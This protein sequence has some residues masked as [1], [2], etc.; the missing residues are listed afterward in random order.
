MRYRLG[1]FTIIVLSFSIGW[2][3]LAYESAIDTT[4][5]VSDPLYFEIRPGQS[6]GRVIDN[7]HSQGLLKN[8]HYFKLMGRLKNAT[9]RLKAG[10]Y[11]IEPGTTW[12]QLLTMMVNG[13]VHQYSITLI[14]GWTF[15][16]IQETIGKSP[17]LLQTLQE[18]SD[19]QIM[20]SISGT[21]EHPEGRFFPDTYFFTKNTTDIAL[22]KRSYMRMRKAL[23]E[24][25]QRREEGLPL[26]TPYQALILASVVE[27]ETAK[28]EE[29]RIIAGVF[30][31]RLQR[32]MK[33]QTD[34]TVIYG[35]GSG[36]QGNIR[37]R[38][39]RAD[40]PY[41]TYVHH[42]LPPTPIAMP[43]RDALHAVLHPQNGSS[44]YF[45]SRG[46]GS[47]VFSSTLREHNRAVAIYQKNM[48]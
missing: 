38:D 44:I 4:L 21:A 29:R 15:A 16:R 42:G 14:E 11:R 23:N 47:H 8:P 28:V 35:M 45:V 10:T 9:G 6:Y 30:I 40:T 17:N 3:W 26:K 20:E 33:L 24:E 43:S 19:E 12:R 27:K 39:L 7:L 2:F 13:R 46:D 5:A 34:P 31:R 41:N 37:Y 36:Y 1:G 48:N 18:K 22:L 25:W 32:G